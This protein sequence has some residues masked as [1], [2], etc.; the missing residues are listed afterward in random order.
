MV[1]AVLS[2]LRFFTRH[3]YPTHIATDLQEAIQWMFP[4]LER[5]SALHASPAVAAEM[6][7]EERERAVSARPPQ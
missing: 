5:R 1:R 6:I 2:G 7:R 3:A 4:H